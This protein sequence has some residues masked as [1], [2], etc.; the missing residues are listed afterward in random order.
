VA[1]RSTFVLVAAAAASLPSCAKPSP[2]RAERPRLIVQITFDQ[3]RGDLLERYRPAFTRGFKRVLDEGWWGRQGDTPHGLTV[4]F[5]GHATLATGMYPSHH[6]LTANEWW[7]EAGGRWRPVSVVSDAR[8]RILGRR[9][10][11]GVSP[12]QMT[13][14]S[15]ADWVKAASPAARTVAI[16]SD[17]AIVYGGRKPDALYWFDASAGGYTTSTYYGV[18]RKS[19]IDALNRRA[20]GLPRAW[21]ISVPP[22]WRRLAQRLSRC[23][24]FGA[25]PTW[26]GARLLGPHR[27][28]PAGG[29]ADAGF[30]SWVGSTPLLDDDLLRQVPAIV[31]DEMLGRD[32]VP[33]YLALAIG[34][35]DS[36][37]HEYGAVSLEQLDTLIRLDR[38]L[39]A[40]LDSLDRVVGKGRY[41]VAISADHGVADPPEETCTHRVSNAEIDALLDR[42]ERIARGHRG[43]RDDLVGKIVAELKRAPFVG[44]VYTE[45]ELASVAPGDWKSELMKRSFRAQ[46]TTDFPLWSER[47]RPFHPARYGISVQF[48]PGVIFSYA[49]AVHGSPYAYDRI[50]PL[51]FY[52]AGVPRGGA[53][54]GGRTVDLAPT[55]AELGGVPRPSNLDGKSL[56]AS[57]RRRR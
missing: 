3:L 38:A 30:L 8:Y 37:G 20:A 14:T 13:A 16:G 46:H 10:E 22:Q 24:P 48:K 41:V 15:L 40:M 49:R 18:K 12:A 36:V 35:T 21:D 44:D 1:K 45:E 11:G 23:T 7:E 17:A 9:A 43:G 19:W 42:V 50:V 2:E 33:D 52:G 28:T 55:L 54:S 25:S 51:I 56:A 26:A 5:P 27:Y 57:W 47:P 4:S 31:R 29:N 32:E 53:R 39:G 6:G 34:A